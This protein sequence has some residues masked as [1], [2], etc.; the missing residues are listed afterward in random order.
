MDSKKHKAGSYD[1]EQESI[2]EMEML[3]SLM[4]TGVCIGGM[5]LGG[6]HYQLWDYKTSQQCKRPADIIVGIWVNSGSYKYF[7][8]QRSRLKRVLWTKGFNPRRRILCG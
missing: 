7:F 5:D 3:L 1:I 6:K 8:V 4:Q 2:E